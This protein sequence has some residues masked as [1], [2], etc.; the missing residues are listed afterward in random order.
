MVKN[1]FEVEQVM[2]VGVAVSLHVPQKF[3]L[4]KRLIKEILIVLYHLETRHLLSVRTNVFHLNDLSEHTITQNLFNLV[5]TGD[6]VSFLELEF[7]FLFISN[8][9]PIIDDS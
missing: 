9:L 8:F 3:K 1:L 4:I 7:F 6:I 2:V 5:S